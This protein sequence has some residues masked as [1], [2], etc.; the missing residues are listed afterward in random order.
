MRT[1]AAGMLASL[2]AQQCRRA[3]FPFESEGERRTW[4]YVPTDHGGLPLSDISAYH[5][6]WV[7]QLL[8]G[9]LSAGGYATATLIMGA[10]PILN[11]LERWLAPG[12][13]HR[14]RIP[15]LYYV[16]IFGDPSTETWGWRFGGHHLSLNYTIRGD[17]VSGTPNF[18]GVDPANTPLIGA[19][20]F[21]PLAG[22]EDI[23]REL[24]TSLDKSQRE[25]AVI[26][27]L[28]PVD[29]VTG[30][31]PHVIPGAR[32]PHLHEL[33]RGETHEPERSQLIAME[34]RAMTAAGI[35]EEHL[36]QL[37]WAR[38]PKGLP[39]SALNPAQ[40]N[41]LD[42][43]LEQYLGRMPDEVA[44]RV[45]ERLSGFEQDLHFAWAGSLTVN[46]AHY[47]RIEGP[48]LLVE[49]D[50]FH[51]SGNHIHSVWRDPED[52]FGEDMLAQHI[53]HDH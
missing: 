8:A 18:F 31:R 34:A 23:A 47:Y 17:A 46:K 11:R 4:F 14:E 16:S 29:I 53:A 33:G 50:N 35:R 1:A 7:F 42:L 5:Q 39:S 6:K 36:A 45:R 52:D 3:S 25:R 13:D 41:L 9:G 24:V 48:R 2:D 22:L 28:A 38:T 30:N 49:Y 21:R 37:E 26:S 20:E 27:E 19:Y 12:D 32:P 40:R 43:V 15:S 44:D 51:R 10:Q